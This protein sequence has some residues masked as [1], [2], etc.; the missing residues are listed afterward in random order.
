MVD[1][2]KLISQLLDFSEQN[3]FY[4][5]QILKRRKENPEMKTGVA[6]IDNFYVYNDQDLEK[7]REK[8]VDRCSKHNARAYI[9]LNR[10]DL[11][12]VALFTMKQMMDYIILGDFKAVKN[13]YA[14]ACGSHHSEKSKR[15]VIDIDAEFLERKEEI[16]KIVDE[17]HKEIPKTNYKILAEVPTKSGVHIIT[18]PFNMEK[19]RKIVMERATSPEDPI[20]KMDVQKNSPTVLYIN[21]M[22]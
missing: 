13:A 7:L 22:A 19:F 21:H 2:F 12:K 16:Y 5:I 17:L 3:T 11:E 4:F 14:T 8:I 18:N 6:V 10:L 15:W 20:L 9:N 1:N